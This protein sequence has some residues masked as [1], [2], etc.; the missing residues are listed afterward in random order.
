MAARSTGAAPRAP[1]SSCCAGKLAHHLLGVAAAERAR[2]H[3]GPAEQLGEHPAVAQQQE[4][5][6]ERMAHDADDE[7][8]AA[9]L[10]LLDE[11]ARGLH[12]LVGERVSASARWPRATA[13]ATETQRAPRRRRSCAP[14]RARTP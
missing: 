3:H 7:L 9:L 2:S 8:D 1:S 5:P 6:G 10:L 13:A 12:V 11:I 14:A 4:R